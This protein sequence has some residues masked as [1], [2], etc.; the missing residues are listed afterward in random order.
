[1]N[2]TPIRLSSI[3]LG[4]RLTYF[5]TLSFPS[6]FFS[7]SYFCNY[8]T[9]NHIHTEANCF[10]VLPCRYRHLLA[11]WGSSTATHHNHQHQSQRPHAPWL[12]LLKQ[13][14]SSVPRWGRQFT[15]Y[16]PVRGQF[17]GIPRFRLPVHRSAT[18]GVWIRLPITQK[19]T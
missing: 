2:L 19:S 6:L 8:Y 3:L 10:L 16:L 11:I 17:N 5:S 12:W 14:R 15:S 13:S 1:M 4:V 7:A 9:F 18:A